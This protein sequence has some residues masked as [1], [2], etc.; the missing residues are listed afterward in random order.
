M[1]SRGSNMLKLPS[2]Y[3]QSIASLTPGDLTPGDLTPTRGV[4]TFWV[5][6]QD[7]CWPDTRKGC[8]YISGLTIRISAWCF[9]LQAC[10][11][12]VYHPYLYAYHPYLWLFRGWRA[13]ASRDVGSS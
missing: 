13:L 3:Y 1:G 9:L 6:D 5:A 2:T 8:H 10:L 12:C 4:T 7:F 11:L